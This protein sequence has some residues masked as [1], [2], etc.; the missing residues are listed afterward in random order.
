MP[1]T[2][3][4]A[5]N[6]VI[7]DGVTADDLKLQY[8]KVQGTIAAKFSFRDLVNV[9]YLNEP[10]KGGT[11]EVARVK[12]ATSQAYGTART[13]GSGNKLENNSADVKIDT[14]REIAEEMN[15]KDLKLWNKLGDIAVL[16]NRKDNFALAMGIELEKAYYVKLQ[17]LAVANGL[18]NVSGESTLQDKLA[19]LIQTLEAVENDNVEKVDRSMMVLTLSSKWYDELEEYFV[20]LENPI[21]GRTDAKAF[22]EVEVRRA[23]RQGFDA[24]VQVVGSVAQPVVFDEFYTAKPTFSNDRYAYMSY[25]FGT[26]GVMPELVFACALDSDISA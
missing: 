16:E 17:Q 18:V 11:V 20:N 6:V 19:L 9:N 23:T 13:A 4:P 1:K 15:A 26:G 7:S 5:N 14:D 25:Y 3:Q 24:I 2:L 21:S 12:T 8:G 22:R 10:I